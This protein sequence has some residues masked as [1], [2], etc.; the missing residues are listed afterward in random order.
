MASKRAGE[1]QDARS[2]PNR[3]RH[4][5]RAHVARHYTRFE[6]YAGAD[7]VGDVDGDGGN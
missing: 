6:K 2:Q 1:R 3:Q 4:A 5:R 7:H